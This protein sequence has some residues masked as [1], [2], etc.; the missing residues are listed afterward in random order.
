ME[1]SFDDFISSLSDEDICN[2]ADINQELANVRNT[3]AYTF[4]VEGTK[5]FRVNEITQ[6]LVNRNGYK[7]RRSVNGQFRYLDGETTVNVPWQDYPYDSTKVLTESE[8]QNLD[9]KELRYYFCS[10][11]TRLYYG[12][13]SVRTNSILI[14]VLWEN[15]INYRK[16]GLFYGTC[17][18]K[19]SFKF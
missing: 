8:Y 11:T 15:L 5:A 7:I 12:N 13:Q 4:Y 18:Y 16:N 3:S 1:K 2:I 6:S 9:T 19:V 14:P 17:V 10:D